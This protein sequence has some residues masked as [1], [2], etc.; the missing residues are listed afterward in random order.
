MSA[1]RGA[2]EMKDNS[3]NKFLKLAVRVKKWFVHSARFSCSEQELRD[4][5]KACVK[6][7]TVIQMR[8]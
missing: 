8:S 3:S 7:V 1:F 5:T 4:L 6:G 2:F